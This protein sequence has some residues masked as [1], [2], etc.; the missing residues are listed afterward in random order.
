[1]ADENILERLSGSGALLEG[2]FLLRS[3]MHSNR[4]FQAAQFLQYPEQAEW[5]C[6]ELASRFGDLNVQTVVS[7]ATGGLIVGHELA[8]ALGARAIFAEKTPDGDSLVFRRGFGIAPG[9]KVLIGEDVITRGGRVRQTVE[10]LESE[11][12]D[13]KGIGVIV[14]RS[15]GDAVFDYPLESLLQLDLDLYPPDDCPLCRQNTELVRPGSK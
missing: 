4:F 15:G 7:P 8:R 1:M 11:K 3:G 13:I 14:D 12:A 6:R 2:H 5:A 10:L 9:E